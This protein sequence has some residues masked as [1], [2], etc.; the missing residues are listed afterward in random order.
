MRLICGS[1]LTADGPFGVA[2]DSRQRNKVQDK[3]FETPG[4]GPRALGL[5][6]AQA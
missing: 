3:V 6:K 5:I 1:Q 4:S 2:L